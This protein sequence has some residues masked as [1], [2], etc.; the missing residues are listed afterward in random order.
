M[1]ERAFFRK[2][3]LV[4]LKA[5]CSRYVNTVCLFYANFC[6]ADFSSDSFE[7]C[8]Q[9]LYKKLAPSLP[10][11]SLEPFSPLVFKYAINR[12][13]FGDLC[14]WCEGRF[15]EIDPT[16]PLRSPYATPINL[17]LASLNRG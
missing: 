15:L 7:F 1:T 4:A 12:N 3:L 11:F 6:L 9:K 14:L 8:L 2:S 5:L 10:K 17:K 16:P 13:C